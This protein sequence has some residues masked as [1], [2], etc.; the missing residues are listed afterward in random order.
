MLYYAN[1]I[2]SNDLSVIGLFDNDL[3]GREAIKINKTKKVLTNAEIISISSANA[4]A[5]TMED[6]LPLDIARDS[7]NT[8]GKEYKTGF[9][10]LTT[11][12]MPAMQ[13][14]TS[15]FAKE[16]VDF[17]DEVKFKISVKVI[18]KFRAL[19]MSKADLNGSLKDLFSL[20]KTIKKKI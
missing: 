2:K 4:S 10:S 18:E 15:H 6:L 20:V 7:A 5:Q 3:A 9:Q 8:V 13:T 11:L 17:T 14:I 16:G 19:K 1:F 12:K